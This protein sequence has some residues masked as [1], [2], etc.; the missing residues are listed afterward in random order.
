ML[1][2]LKINKMHNI[3][4]FGFDR[5]HTDNAFGL[6][7]FGNNVPERPYSVLVK[8]RLYACLIY[9][10]QYL[11]E[12]DLVAIYYDVN[13]GTNSHYPGFEGLS[14][15]LNKNLFSKVLFWDLESVINIEYLHNQLVKL[16]SCFRNLEFFD[17]DG[18]LFQFDQ[19]PLNQ[20]IGV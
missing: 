16:S 19:L 13:D 10:K 8:R 6:Y 9:V 12:D 20:L 18:N 17:L 1:S 11:K 15:D 3:E 4:Y 2:N 14:A 7:V 5:S